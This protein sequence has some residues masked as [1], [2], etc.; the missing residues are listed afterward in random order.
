MWLPT[1]VNFNLPLL[2]TESVI[3]RKEYNAVFP[4]TIRNDI[5]FLMHAR[6]DE[7]V[8]IHKSLS[9]STFTVVS[10]RMSYTYYSVTMYVY[11][12]YKIYMLHLFFLF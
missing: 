11:Y 1:T 10:C 2:P 8:H 12:V 5:G 3:L 4:V 9:L 7:K 6:H